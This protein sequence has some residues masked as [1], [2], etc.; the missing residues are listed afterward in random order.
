[1]SLSKQK[2]NTKPF[3]RASSEHR[4]IVWGG[5]EI[6]PFL[7]SPVFQRWILAVVT[8]LAVAL[9]FEYPRIKELEVGDYSVGDIAEEDI[10]APK[11]TLVEDRQATEGKI[12]IAV[13][14]TWPVFDYDTA[15]AQK[16]E[17]SM[18]SGFDEIRNF[19]QREWDWVDAEKK[20]VAYLKANNRRSR[21]KA[22]PF[23][24]DDDYTERIAELRQKFTE[25]TSEYG[26]KTL[27]I[28]DRVWSALEKDRFSKDTE[29]KIATLFM[30]L[31]VEGVVLTKDD[32]PTEKG[33]GVKVRVLPLIEGSGTFPKG[34]V[35]TVHSLDDVKKLIR[36]RASSQYGRE[37]SW[38]LRNALVEITHQLILPN[39]TFNKA[40]TQAEKNSA[41]ETVSKV[42]I[43][44]KKGEKIV[45]Q[46]EAI[47]EK[48][49]RRLDLVK[50]GS[51]RSN[52]LV[53]IGGNF[54]W[55]LAFIAV[56]YAFA[57]RNIRK[58]DPVNKDLLHMALLTVFLVAMLKIVLFGMEGSESES[59]LNIAYIVPMVAGAMMVR[60]VINSEVA[61]TFSVMISVISAYLAG[62]PVFGLFVMVGSLVGA[63]EVGRARTR[64]AL[65]K[66][67]LMTGMANIV[68]VLA[69]SISEGVF[70]EP[71]IFYNAM[72][73]LGGGIIASFLVLGI[74]P[75]VENLFG[76]VTDIRLLE[77]A[78]QEHPLLKALIMNAP[79]TYQHSVTLGILAEEGAMAI[80]VNPLLV[81]VA[82]LYHDIGKMEKPVYFVENQREKENPHD[83]LNPSMSS[84]I[85]GSHVKYGIEL[86]KMY[87]LP[88]VII[89]AIPQHHGTSMMKYFY[90]KA[91]EREDPELSPVEEK[92]FRYPGPKP[93]TRETAILM[94]ADSVEA[95]ARS[96]PDPAPAKL[97]NLV[98]KIIGNI[99]ND[100]QLDECEL[101]LKDLNSI[102]EAFINTLS[103]MYH[104]RPEY[105]ELP[106]DG[107]DAGR[108]KIAD[109]NSTG[110][111]KLEAGREG[112]GEDKKKDKKNSVA[113]EA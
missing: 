33:K 24:P 22:I 28:S 63:E 6:D 37:I 27:E 61:L 32:L 35:S 85:I 95:A 52:A 58:F 68:I 49:M 99:F 65:A 80:H 78:N 94:L 30:Q 42:Y 89:D 54:M 5:V 29:N 55:L 109:K 26:G 62:D 82:A 67:G 25:V 64:S 108:K 69:V 103:H 39:Y 41:G 14:E 92:D 88:K 20:R 43:Q 9:L 48:V 91:K 90:A 79:G 36:D 102:T 8:A 51:D 106:Q 38:Q 111:D 72:L 15:L 110:K 73:A 45:G 86:A 46:G 31:M 87:R 56:L 100:G 17:K 2:K 60:L 57:A 16:I 76:Y 105:P 112:K 113:S 34:D 1:M 75:L 19:H 96:L 53:G 12:K 84:L 4:H 71:V 50:R 21:Q 74:T 11:D 66:A 23:I 47:T 107:D 104:S 3:N 81:K 101:T 59:H 97:R 77:L 44:I 83:N 10:Y 98:K 40:Q 7:M 18:R 93:Q 70:A 13:R